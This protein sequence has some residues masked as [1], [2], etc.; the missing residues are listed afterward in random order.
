MNK[1]IIFFSKIFC[2]FINNIYIC[3]AAGIRRIGVTNKTDYK[4]KEDDNFPNDVILSNSAADGI[5]AFR[6]RVVIVVSQST[7]LTHGHASLNVD[8]VAQSN[9]HKTKEAYNASYS[10][11]ITIFKCII[12]IHK[13]IYKYIHTP[14]EYYRDNI[15]IGCDRKQTIAF[16]SQSYS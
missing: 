14:Y 13:Y 1:Y 2:G 12:C 15:A 3:T 6:R 7:S 5:K 4:G 10:Q 11:E 8:E 9:P 16:S